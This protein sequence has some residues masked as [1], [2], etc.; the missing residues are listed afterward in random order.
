MWRSRS[1]G[2]SAPAALP[3]ARHRDGPLAEERRRYLAHCAEQQMSRHT[4]QRIASNTLIVA[5]GEG[6]EQFGRGA[7]GR[8]EGD[9]GTARRTGVGSGRIGSVAARP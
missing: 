5:E 2:E 7:G 9:V 1:G 6:Q 4:L 8:N 3:Q